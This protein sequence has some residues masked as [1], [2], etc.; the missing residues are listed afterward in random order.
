MIFVAGRWKVPFDSIISLFGCKRIKSDNCKHSRK[1]NPLVCLSM[2][3]Q[4]ARSSHEKFVIRLIHSARA[5]KRPDKTKQIPNQLVYWVIVSQW[6]AEMRKLLTICCDKVLY[7]DF[8]FLLVSFL[9]FTLLIPENGAASTV[10]A[11]F[12]IINGPQRR[13]ILPLQRRKSILASSFVNIF[14]C[15]VC[16]LCICIIV[17]KKSRLIATNRH[18]FD[19]R[20]I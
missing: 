2:C 6:L 7:N 4:A 8:G 16:V 12:G 3:L 14:V 18:F 19:L 20:W 1:S 13:Q 11:V 10:R 17:K 9:F 5:V 15:A